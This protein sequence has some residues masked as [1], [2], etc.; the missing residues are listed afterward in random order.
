LV[1]FLR[2]LLGMARRIALVTSDPGLSQVAKEAAGSER[3]ELMRFE[4][5]EA[6]LQADGL[7][8]DAHIVVDEGVAGMSPFELLER[9]RD[10]HPEARP[11]L[12]SRTPTFEGFV[13]GLRGGA[14]DVLFPPV[15][16]DA[17]Q[18]TIQADEGPAPSLDSVPVDALSESPALVGGH[19]LMKDVYRLILAFADHPAP[20]LITGETGTGKGVVAR[21]IHAMSARRRAP[22]RVMNCAGIAS[23]VLE[24]EVFGHERG[25][26]S[27]A[28]QSRRGYLEAVGRGTLLLDEIG[29]ASAAFQSTL[30]RVLEERRYFRVGGDD[31]REF[32]GR[33]IAATNRNL[34]ERVGEG[35]FREDLIFRLEVLHIH[36]PPLCERGGDLEIL[37]DHFLT[38]QAEG[39]GRPRKQ[40]S[41]NALRK[42]RRHP[43]SGNV[44]E[45][46]HVLARAEVLSPG[47]VIEARHVRLESGA[48]SQ[49]AGSDDDRRDNPAGDHNPTGGTRS[50]RY[51]RPDDPA[52]ERAKI[53]QELRDAGWN[54][55][56]AARSMGMHRAT[57]WRRMK[58]LG[59]E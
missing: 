47:P 44:R 46:A 9:L 27:G 7:V 29:D 3:L 43:W 24:S 40:L 23:G 2:S 8:G 13:A 39:A 10:R 41:R 33:V 11:L 35:R 4:T 20:V 31:E 21:A 28:E 14:D 36:M 58:E 34:R 48:G 1:E 45:L 12:I 53:L 16:P 19:P 55:E 32:L 26:F 49:A 38:S 37:V 51:V 15:E 56:R 57:L 5:A 54:R 42:L 52:V 59:I 6:A 50:R 22:F 30:L 17:L 18:R 25:A